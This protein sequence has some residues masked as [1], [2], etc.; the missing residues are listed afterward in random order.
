[1]QTTSNGRGL[2]VIFDLDGVLVDSG[3]AHKQAWRDLGEREGFSMSEEVFCRTFGLQNCEIIP[4]LLERDVSG[5]EMA[6]MSDWKEQRY[7]ELIG[8]RLVPAEGAAALVKDLK[9]EGFA[10]AV[11]SSAPREN[12]ELILGRLQVEAYFDALVTCED[13][14]RSKPAPDTFLKAAEKLGLSPGRC[15]VVE[16]AVA[17]VQAG[18]AAGMSVV[19]VTSTKSRAELA[20]ADIVVDSL[21]ELG[22]GDFVR[23]LRSGAI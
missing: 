20:K 8:E 3:W 7:R 1:M 23:L 12:L 17:G 19:A 10:L 18:K 2:G 4:M 14:G 11:G 6:R 22:A 16:D 15:A 13:V 21:V 5:E 9:G